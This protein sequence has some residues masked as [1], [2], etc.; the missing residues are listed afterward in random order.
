MIRLMKK[1]IIFVIAILLIIFGY[2][3]YMKFSNDSIEVLS[4][5]GS[6]GE[7]VRQIQQKLK[8]WGYYTGDV[9]RKVWK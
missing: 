5:Y 8:N 1:V 2:V 6:S 4:K 9:D 7:E 3:Y